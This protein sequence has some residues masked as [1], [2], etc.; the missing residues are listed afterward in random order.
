MEF[1][2]YLRRA[3]L[4]RVIDG[5]TVDLIIDLGWDL[6]IAERCRLLDIDTPEVRGPEREDGR[7]YREF[8]EQWFEKNSGFW[9]RSINYKRGKYGRTIAEVYNEDMSECLNVI[10]R[11]KMLDEGLFSVA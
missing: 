11:D 1:D 7:R 2:E 9:V 10:L 6:N 8:V 3:R 5:D 4:E